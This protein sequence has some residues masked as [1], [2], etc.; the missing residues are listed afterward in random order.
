VV[1]SIVTQC[2]LVGANVSEERIACIFTVEMTTGHHNPEATID[3]FTAVINS[4]LKNS[5]YLQMSLLSYLLTLFVSS[6]T[7]FPSD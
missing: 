4:N 1:F 5:S 3:I 7:I 6:F 2:S